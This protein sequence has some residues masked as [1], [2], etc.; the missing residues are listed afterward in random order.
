VQ[1][2]TSSVRPM[3]I[4]FSLIIPKSDSVSSALVTLVNL[5]ANNPHDFPWAIGWT[6]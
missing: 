3:N 4:M 1:G 6:G 5:G 2:E